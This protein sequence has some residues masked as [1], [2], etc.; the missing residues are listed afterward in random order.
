MEIILQYKSAAPETPGLHI[1]LHLVVSVKIYEHHCLYTFYLQ[2]TFI[3]Y[4]K[5]RST[6]SPIEEIYALSTDTESLL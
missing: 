1:N 3:R 4:S 2:S 5:E 6:T